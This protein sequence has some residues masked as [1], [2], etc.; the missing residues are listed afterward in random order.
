MTRR[1]KQEWSKMVHQ[2]C[3]SGE[4]AACR[5]YSE[6]TLFLATRDCCINGDLGRTYRLQVQLIS[7]LDVRSN[8]VSNELTEP[9]RR[10]PR[11]FPSLPS[12]QSTSPTPGSEGPTIKEELCDLL[13]DLVCDPQSRFRRDSHHSRRAYTQA[14]EAAKGLAMNDF[15]RDPRLNVPNVVADDQLK[16]GDPFDES[17]F[18]WQFRHQMFSG[19]LPNDTIDERIRLRSL[20]APESITGCSTSFDIDSIIGSLSHLGKLRSALKILTIQT[21]IP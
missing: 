13:T 1:P 2:V 6:P 10:R 9:S 12:S 7:V 15:L 18:S 11:P 20:P 5:H 14:P 4:P 21:P 8:A 17:T 19:F 3:L 16:R